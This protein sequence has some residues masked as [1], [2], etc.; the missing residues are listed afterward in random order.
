M[1]TLRRVLRRG[2]ILVSRFLLATLPATQACQLIRRFTRLLP[3]EWGQ[4]LI[5]R[6]S[7][8]LDKFS[9]PVIAARTKHKFAMWLDLKDTS[10]QRYLFFLGEWEADATKAIKSILREGDVFFDLGANV[11]YFS[12][13]GADIVGSGG[14]IYAFEAQSTLCSQLRENLSLNE[15]KNVRVV[16]VA[17]TDKVCDLVI[18]DVSAL[19]NRGAATLL[20]RRSDM[21]VVKVAGTSVDDFCFSEGIERVSL[22]K[23][24]IEGSEMLALRGMRALLSC[25][26]APTLLC[27]INEPLLQRMGSSGD[28]LRSYLADLGYEAYELTEGGPRK[29]ETSVRTLP[30]NLLGD[31]YVFAKKPAEQR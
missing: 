17:V 25:P 19:G 13:V 20:P 31:N 11:G 30:V 26:Q 29:L 22:I 4:P 3:W 23:M 28:E 18:E 7:P 24:D 8:V 12:L 10:I 6:L 5:A 14:R 16:N 1:V 9:L 27:E 21:P 2:F 15:I